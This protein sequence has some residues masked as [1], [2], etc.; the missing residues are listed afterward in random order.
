MAKKFYAVLKGHKV[1]T[2]TTWAACQSAT[3]GYSG[4]TFK[5]FTTKEEADLYL[6]NTATLPG[7]LPSKSTQAATATNTS[8]GLTVVL[9]Y[10][11][12]VQI[13]TDGACDPNPG[14]TG[15]GLV[16]YEYGKL[17]TLKYGYHSPNGTN[18]TAE[19]IAL[20]EAIKLASHYI[21]KGL[22][23]EILSDSDYSLKAVFVWSE[24]WQKK[25]WTKSG[26]AP[27]QNLELIKEC[28]A[29]SRPLISKVQMT[30]VRAHAGTEGNELADR[31]SVQAQLKQVTGWTDFT[32]ETSPEKIL[33][34][35]R[36]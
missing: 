24:G 18:N 19:L 7:A 26:N 14:A 6:G 10:Q 3:K 35:S 33:A 36:G 30:H 13:Y 12:P 21:D 29:L 34:L 8:E 5:S 32:D 28:Y 16:V 27:I 25:N 31:L 23:V 15:S 1:G 17:T 11:F 9:A 20:R 2:F 4:A 22:P